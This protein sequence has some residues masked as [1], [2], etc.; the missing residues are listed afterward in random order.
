MSFSKMIELLQNKDKGKIILINAGAF[1]IER[2]KDAVLLHNIL[3]L[4]VNCM[5]TEICK[6]GF[7]LNALE[8]YT[9]LIEDK[10]YSYIVYNYDKN[11]EKLN[12]IKQYNGKKL[13][14]LEEKKLNC[15]IC[16]N[17]VKIYKK[18]DKYI[19]AVANLY[20]EDEK[21]KNI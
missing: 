5:Q 21:E 14:K 17:K 1:Y 4:K 3:D 15:Y 6:V 10:N 8:K 20:E 12:I 11:I 19:K 18:D 7:P 2:G 16:K 9:K 13:N